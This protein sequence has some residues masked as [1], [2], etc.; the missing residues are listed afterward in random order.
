MREALDPSSGEAICLPDTREVRVDL[1][2]PRYSV[3]GGVIKVEPKEDIKARINRS[4]D[5]GDA[6]VMA[7]HGVIAGKL[8]MPT[9]L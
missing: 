8:V 9:F 7:W 6:I 1:T 5:D 3:V 2:A 4:P